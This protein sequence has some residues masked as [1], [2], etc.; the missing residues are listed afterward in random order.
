MAGR[1]EVTALPFAVLP[2]QFY[3]LSPWFCCLQRGGGRSRPSRAPHRGRAGAL[4]GRCRGSLTHAVATP[5]HRISP[6]FTA[7]HRGTA[8]GPRAP[9]RLRPRERPQAVGVHKDRHSGETSFP[10]LGLAAACSV[11]IRVVVPELA[12]SR[13]VLSTTRSSFSARGS[14]VGS[15]PGPSGTSR[16]AGCR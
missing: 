12:H 14:S 6:Q 16:S 13:T 3:G 15:R 1:Q 9:I 8:V 11:K 7:F 10:Q 5:F 4:R 2:P